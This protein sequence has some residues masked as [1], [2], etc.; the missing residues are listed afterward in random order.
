MHRVRDRQTDGQTTASCQQPIIGYC[1]QQYDRLTTLE[2]RFI[3]NSKC[4]KVFTSMV[5]MTSAILTGWCKAYK[6][7]QTHRQ[8]D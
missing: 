3:K 1:M 2:M 8:T 6:E 5:R 7:C 4:K